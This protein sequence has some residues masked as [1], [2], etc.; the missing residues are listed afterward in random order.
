VE[1]LLSRLNEKYRNFSEKIRRE[2]TLRSLGYGWGD[3]IQT[4]Q[5]NKTWGMDWIYLAQ[6][7]DH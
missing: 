5:I 1:L 2:E 4:D 3:S 7:K 6:D